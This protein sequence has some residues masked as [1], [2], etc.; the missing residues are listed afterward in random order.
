MRGHYSSQLPLFHAFMI[1]V[2]ALHNSPLIFQ[3]IN[4][5]CVCKVF[6]NTLKT[7]GKTTTS[8][9]AL[10]LLIHDMTHGCSDGWI[11]G[12]FDVNAFTCPD[13]TVDI[14]V[15]HCIDI[16]HYSDNGGFVGN[17]MTCADVD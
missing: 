9:K 11:T 16:R 1:F 6:E 12:L 4:I 13:R 3:K 2:F 8:D 17:Q 14:R 15:S 10:N 5:Q 7:I